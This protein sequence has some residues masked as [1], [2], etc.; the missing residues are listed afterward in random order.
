MLSYTM[1][2]YFD[3]SGYCDMA[4][5]IA[6]MFNIYLPMNFSSP[7]RAVSI[8]E[9]W[10]RWH[11]T[12]TRF[13]TNY[14]YIPLGG[15]RKGL[16]RTCLHILIVFVISGLWHGAQW[17]FVFWGFL[18]GVFMVV[19]RLVAAARD[20][21]KQKNAPQKATRL[22]KKVLAWGIT[23]LFVNITWLYFRADSIMIAN[24]MLH[25][26]FSFTA[27]EIRGELFLIYAG[28]LL[29]FVLERI[30]VITPLLYLIPMIFMLVLSMFLILCCKNTS[31]IVQNVKPTY[32]T[33]LAT[34]FL[35]LAA[36]VSLGGE[37]AFLYFNF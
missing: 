27:F 15:N 29:R 22:I 33:A 16:I 17:T 6:K 13:L 26:A 18:H 36:I 8:R 14:V 30:D 23:F 1:Q 28:E 9:F 32:R 24:Q 5:G 31:Q 2:I 4:G 19:E 34:I 20:K 12:L 21:R 25:R 35:L 11:I 37:S 10:D 3:F 7:Y